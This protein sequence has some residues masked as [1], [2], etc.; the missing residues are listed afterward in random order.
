MSSRRT[1]KF[2][3]FPASDC[4]E[5]Q[6]DIQRALHRVMSGGNFILGHEVQAFEEAF[7]SYLG[8]TH[9][10]GVG[11]GTDAIELMLRALGIGQGDRVAVPCFVPSAVAAGVERS[12]ATVVLVDVD[13]QTLTLCPR[14]LS[15]LLDSVEG[16]GVRAALAVHLYGHP[17]DWAE[18]Q[19]VALRHGI[20][21][22]EDCAQA[23]GA[24]WQGLSTGTLGRMAAFSFYPT[25][26]LGALGDAGAVTTRDAE[27][28]AR[29]RQLRQYGWQRRH[30][31]ERA[32]INSRM[33]ELQ[34]AVL[35]VKLR[36]LDAQVSQRRALA[37]M[38]DL[39]LAD[40]P[41]I[42][43]P[44][45]REGCGHAFHQ[46]VIRSPHRDAVQEHLERQ[47]IP[48]AVLYPA[49]LHQQPAW[50]SRRCFPVA[51]RAAAEVLSLPLHP[52]LTKDAIQQ[53][54]AAIRS[55]HHHDRCRA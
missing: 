45:V 36:S 18:L 3:A 23:H 17:A 54:T 38:Y 7:A 49:A 25:K 20:D 29:V 43:T 44:E 9:A 31:S 55:L 37:A 2:P 52:H 26:N 34:A 51:E 32:G 40:S 4:L 39:D 41:L 16:Q 12:G 1:S 15:R 8:T 13:E 22:L 50:H 14:A 33:D 48:A 6:E 46:Y 27:L 53:V 19:K 28:A 10:V 47:G 5:H 21:L 11:S 35:R 24:R 30:V 42:T